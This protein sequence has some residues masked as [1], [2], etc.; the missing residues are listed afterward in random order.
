MSM[1]EHICRMTF[2]NK[3]IADLT[4]K[5]QKIKNGSL[6]KELEEDIE[7]YQSTIVELRK[8]L[9]SLRSRGFLARL[10]NWE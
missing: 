8:E 5:T 9:E 1:W 4:Q 10:F 7:R 6:V 2:Q 3:R